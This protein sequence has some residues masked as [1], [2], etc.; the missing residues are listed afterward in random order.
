MIDGQDG[1]IVAANRARA[2]HEMHLNQRLETPMAQKA[3]IEVQD[4]FGQ[5]RYFT[6]VTVLGSNVKL[7]LQRALGS[8]QARD[9]GKAR[10]RDEETGELLDI[11]VA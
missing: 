9:S 8:A 2:S 5:W 7:A 4:Q 1:R 11:E 3:R 10:A 6:T